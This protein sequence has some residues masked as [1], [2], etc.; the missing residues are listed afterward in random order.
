[1]RLS[2]SLSP[3]PSPPRDFA[4]AWKRSWVA[5]MLL[6]EGKRRGSAAVESEAASSMNGFLGEETM[7]GELAA[8]GVNARREW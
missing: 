7:A 8:S 1:M 5:G 6:G 2:P 4:R 3:S